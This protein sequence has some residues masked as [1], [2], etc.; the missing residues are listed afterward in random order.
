[1]HSYIRS[2]T[3]S[4]TPS[5][6]ISASL[7]PVAKKC[8]QGFF[9]KTS[10]ESMKSFSGVL[11]Q[12]DDAAGLTLVVSLLYN[13][14]KSMSDEE[15]LAFKELWSELDNLCRMGDGLAKAIRAQV[16]AELTDVIRAQVTAEL[17]EVNRA[18]LVKNVAELETQILAHKRQIAKERSDIRRLEGLNAT[19]A[20]ELKNA[21][22]SPPAP[23]AA[24]A[25]PATPKNAKAPAPAMPAPPP[26]LAAAAALTVDDSD[27]DK[28]AGGADE[29]VDDS[30]VPLVD[31]AVR[32]R[33][34]AAAPAKVKGGDHVGVPAAKKPR[35]N[36]GGLKGRVGGCD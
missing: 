21:K 36:L 13:S 16:T 12:M 32:L 11:E 29:V 1:M 30:Q 3:M 26:A 4:T 14:P 5:I 23:Q 19:L 7:F 35:V 22:A 27:E 28:V 17:A 6:T 31:V 20:E 9:R 8:I 24:P 10:S 15:K 25:M 2:R 33:A 18:D 34:A